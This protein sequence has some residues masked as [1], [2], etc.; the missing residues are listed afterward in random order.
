MSRQCCEVCERPLKTCI[1]AF[2]SKVDNETHVFVLQ[3]PSEVNQTKGTV[4]LLEHSL[5][6][7]KVFVGEN[8]TSHTELHDALKLF[9]EN[10]YLLYPSEKALNV[11]DFRLNTIE[12]TLATNKPDSANLSLNDKKSNCLIILDGTWKK[13]YRLF[14]LN[15]FLQDIP[16]LTLPEGL[17]GGYVIRKTSKENALSS[18]EACC[19]A[20]QEIEQN[21]A[22]Y[23]PLFDNFRKFN[24]FQMQFRP[25]HHFPK[26]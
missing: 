7:I 24:A 21:T 17:S 1:C 11:V 9:G 26:G 20:L 15:S 10:V 18:L 16:H 6:Q 8:F 5:A 4:A 19:Y 23:K 13:A 3:H 25:H 2:I 22:R 14:M 12:K